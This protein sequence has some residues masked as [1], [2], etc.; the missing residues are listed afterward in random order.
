MDEFEKDSNL[1]TTNLIPDEKAS[2]GLSLTFRHGIIIINRDSTVSKFFDPRRK[3]LYFLYQ[4]TL[5]VRYIVLTTEVREFD[6]SSRDH[7]TMM[8]RG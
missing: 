2:I 8:V 7:V 1:N 3:V 6:H 4:R 5:V